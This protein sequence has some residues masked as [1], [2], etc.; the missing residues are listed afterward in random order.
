MS[1]TGA[2]FTEHLE[3]LETWAKELLGHEDPAVKAVGQDVEKTVTELKTDAG[4]VEVEAKGD[5]EKVATDAETAAKPVL[6]EAAKAGETVA[7][8]AVADV[9]KSL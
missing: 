8:E 7:A 2:W 1:A 4:T 5:A 9:G 6:A 3:K